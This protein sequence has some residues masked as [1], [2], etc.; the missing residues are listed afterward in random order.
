MIEKIFLDVLLIMS[1]IAMGTVADRGDAEHTVSCYIAGACG[2]FGA[3]YLLSFQPRGHAYL[4]IIVAMV[5]YPLLCAIGAFGPAK[6]RST[7]RSHNT[8]NSTGHAG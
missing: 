3:L 8:A 7:F 4:N 1:P 5:A 2:Y 6:F